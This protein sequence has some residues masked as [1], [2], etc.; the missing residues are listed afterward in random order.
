[1]H[2]GYLFMLLGFSK[3]T[4]LIVWEKRAFN[5]LSLFAG[6]LAFGIG[7]VCDRVGLLA[8]GTQGRDYRGSEGRNQGGRIQLS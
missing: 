4:H 6:G 1:M 2:Y 7:Y 5:A 3:K 8:R